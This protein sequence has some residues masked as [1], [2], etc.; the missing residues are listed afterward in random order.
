VSSHYL[1]DG[2]STRHD[3]SPLFEIARVLVCLNHVARFIVNA[4][5]IVMGTAVKLGVLGFI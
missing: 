2:A 1:G 3:R 4:N 5:H